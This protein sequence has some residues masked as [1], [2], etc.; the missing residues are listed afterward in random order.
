ME[1]PTHLKKLNINI[2]KGKLFK[3]RMLK[4]NAKPPLS[5]EKAIALFKLKFN[6]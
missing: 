1:N 6:L 5:P 3:K 4:N 2:H